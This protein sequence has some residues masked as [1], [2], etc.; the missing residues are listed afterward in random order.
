MG[1]SGFLIFYKY[2]NQSIMKK[3]TFLIIMVLIPIMTNAQF[4]STQED[5]TYLMTV[6]DTEYRWTDEAS[7]NQLSMDAEMRAHITNTLNAPKQVSVQSDRMMCMLDVDCSNIVDADLDC[8]ADLPPVDFDLPIINDACPTPADVILSAL[9]I[10]PGNSGCPGDPVIVP[11]TYFIQDGA[12]NMTQCE[13]TFTIESTNDPTLTAASPTVNEML[14]ASCEFAL[15][16]YTGTI[17][18]TS[19]CSSP[20]ITQSPAPGT[21]I[22]G[23]TTTTVTFSVTDFCGRMATTTI[24]VITQDMVPPT[25]SCVAPFTVALDDMGM[26]TITAADV[27]NGSTDDCGIATLSIDVTDFSCADIGTPVTVTLTVTDVNANTATCTTTVTVVDNEDPVFQGGTT[28]P[29]VGTNYTLDNTL[30]ANYQSITATG[31]ILGNGDDTAFTATLGAPFTIYGNT[32]GSLRVATN[33]YISINLTDNGPDLSNDCP[34]PSVPSTGVDTARLYPLHDDLVA[35]V[36]YEYFTTSPYPH[37]NGDIM[38]A[39]VIEWLGNHFSGGAIQAQAILFDNGDVIYQYLTDAEDGSGSTIGAQ[40][41]GSGLAVTAACNTA[42]TTVSAGIY[43]LSPYGDVLMNSPASTTDA[44]PMTMTVESDT[45]DCGAIVT[46]DMPMAVDNC[47]GVT[48]AQTAGLA[49]GSEFPLGTTTN[50]FIATDASGNTATCTFDVVVQDTTPITVI[51]GPIDIFTGTGASA[52]DC[53]TVVNYDPVTI[54]SFVLDD[55]CGDLTLATVVQTGGLGSGAMFPVGTNTEEFTITDVNGNETIYTFDIVITDTTLPV[56]DCP[57]EVVVA[58]DDSGSYTID[59]FT[60]SASDNCSSGP[61]LVV[62]QDPA[63]GTVVTEPSTTA[64]T[65]TA[66]D[67]AGNTTTCSFDLVVDSTL[68][69][70]DNVLDGS[71]ISVYPNPAINDITIDAGTTEMERITIYDLHG[72]IVAKMDVASIKTQIDV[73]TYQTGI[74]LVNVAVNGQTVTKRLIKQ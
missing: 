58:G 63:P 34:L 72:R 21:V 52:G 46:F 49:S 62:T 25:A 37:P 41:S 13:Q 38:G 18:L 33:G 4:T 2:L 56:I 39:S 57:D 23:A 48:V 65:V 67:A 47:A 68:S 32:V 73:S 51:S 70:S 55:N 10:I 30:V 31:A 64:I 42:G 24:D 14:D 66:T 7:F 43:G 1:C 22:S 16:D 8:R 36:Y 71:S 28:S 17:T 3:I 69:L 11:R 50:T 26:A 15:A 59:D 40:E 5:V 29:P 27:D 53:A 60:A 74:Y 61:D 35:T 6:G 19:D 45:P 12:G 54:D 20:A 44:C 9:T